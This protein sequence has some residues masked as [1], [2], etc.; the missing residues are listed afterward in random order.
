[1][2]DRDPGQLEAELG[3]PQLKDRGYANRFFGWF[4]RRPGP[5]PGESIDFGTPGALVAVL[6]LTAF[7]AVGAAVLATHR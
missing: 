4:L 6:F 7:V 3:R 5:A 2:T 1:V